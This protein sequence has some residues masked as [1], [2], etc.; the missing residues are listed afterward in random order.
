MFIV[1]NIKVGDLVVSECGIEGVLINRG[2]VLVGGE[3]KDVL[4]I[5]CKSG[6][7]NLFS[8]IYSVTGRVYLKKD[9]DYIK[10]FKH[11]VGVVGDF[12]GLP[13][14]VDTVDVVYGALKTSINMQLYYDEDDNLL[15]YKEYMQLYYPEYEFV[16]KEQL[17]EN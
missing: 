8:E 15:T 5:E 4:S 10:S 17:D 3:C 2:W 6:L 7:T 13:I 16:W 12:H 1:I 14:A 9:V 11:M